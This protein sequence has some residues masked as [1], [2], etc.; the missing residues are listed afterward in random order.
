MQLKLI[1]TVVP[2]V[3]LLMS[4][5]VL[6]KTDPTQF[7]EPMT[8]YKIYTIEQVRELVKDTKAFTDAIRHGQ[9]ARA[10]ALYA[11]ARIHYER[12]EPVAEL[13]SDLDSS[14]DARADDYEKG[15][16]D[17]KFTGFHRLEKGLWVDD[18][19]R[20]LS[21]YADR[22]DHDVQ[23]LQT[24]LT[25]MTF[26]PSDVVD[27]AAGLIEEVASSKISGEEDRYSHTDLSDFQANVDGSKTIVDL[28][29]PL[30]KK[31][32]AAFLNKVDRNFKVVDTILAK[33]RTADGFETYDKLTKADRKALQGPVTVLA[34]ELSTLRG[35]LGLN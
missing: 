10:K 9:L 11:P 34:E 26:P 8:E 31:D 32:N 14:I 19:T 12:I 3:C 35:I 25:K 33:Y 6:A 21:G 30:L 18:S 7:V 5:Q 17:P 23:D 29:R 20:G 27:G 28:L 22:L 15:A 24:R 16:D 2:A 13:F 1:R 4:A